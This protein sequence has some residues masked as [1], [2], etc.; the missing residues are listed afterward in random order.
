MHKMTKFSLFLNI[1]V[2]VPVCFGIL[3]GQDFVAHGWGSK[4]PSLY[5]LVSIYCTILFF[6]FYLLIKPNQYLI[7]SLLMMQ[8][9][10][11][12][13]SPILVGSLQNPVVLSNIVISAVH[14]I[15]LYFIIKSPQFSLSDKA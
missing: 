10:Y 9:V 11:K 12:L 8:V 6:S 7:F 2:L 14:L 1:G 13:L 4:Q 5:I 3:S 15:S